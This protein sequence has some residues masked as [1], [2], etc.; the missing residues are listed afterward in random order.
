MEI[1]RKGYIILMTFFI[2]AIVSI[3]INISDIIELTFP[4]FIKI[5]RQKPVI[6][7]LVI[8]FLCGWTLGLV[9]F[10][11]QSSE[12]DTLIKKAE[13]K[14]IEHEKECFGKQER[15]FEN[16]RELIPLQEEIE[17]AGIIGI[18]DSRLSVKTKINVMCVFR[19]NPP[20]ESD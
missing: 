20:P 1:N 10:F 2:V 3:L 5:I 9:I 7:S 6:S 8:S 19:R 16:L 17:K 12:I 14:F 13:G 4:Q 15:Y 11:L 18:F